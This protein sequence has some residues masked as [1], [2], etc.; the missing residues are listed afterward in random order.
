MPAKQAKV[1]LSNNHSPD[2]PLVGLE[3]LLPNTAPDCKSLSAAL[4]YTWPKKLFVRTSALSRF[5]SA[6]EGRIQ[7]RQDTGVWLPLLPFLLGQ[8]RRFRA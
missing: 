8:S 2:S 4:E 5:Y 1:P 7:Y 3:A 6:D